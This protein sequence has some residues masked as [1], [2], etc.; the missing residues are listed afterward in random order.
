MTITNQIQVL[1]WILLNSW[2]YVHPHQ[3]L[4]SPDQLTDGASPYV[5]PA[6]LRPPTGRYGF[7]FPSAQS[8]KCQVGSVLLEKIDEH[9]FI[10]KHLQTNNPQKVTESDCQVN[11]Q[12][13]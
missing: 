10:S 8:L 7:C 11:P 1:T 6:E 13:M 5:Q 12:R 2:G 9:L 4:P 3:Q